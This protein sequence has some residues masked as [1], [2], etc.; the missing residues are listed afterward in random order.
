MIVLTLEQIR[1][2]P[3]ETREWLAGLLPLGP[4]PEVELKPEP[5]PEPEPKP[6]PE[7]ASDT[8][9][10]DPT[11]EDAVHAAKALID[12]R[13]TDCLQKIIDDIGGHRV[14]DCPPEHL[15]ELMSRMAAAMEGGL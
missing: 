9:E 7:P 5:E 6:E 10:A 4:T 11:H 1:T 13:G 3:E 2:A 14:R 8:T 15:P 12:K